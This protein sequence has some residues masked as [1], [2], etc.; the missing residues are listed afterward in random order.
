MSS[1]RDD[2]DDV[3][4]TSLSTLDA[5]TDRTSV[6][7]SEAR[8][9]F[10]AWAASFRSVRLIG[11]GVSQLSETSGQGTLFEQRD[12]YIELVVLF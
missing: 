9:L 12:D 11:V 8:R 3:F 6:I 7:A 1:A 5:P 10:D 2:G 4:M